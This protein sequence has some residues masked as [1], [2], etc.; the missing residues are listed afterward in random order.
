MNLSIVSFEPSTIFAGE[1]YSETGR[2]MVPVGEG[3]APLPE[4]VVGGFWIA[5]NRNF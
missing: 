3:T 2:F 4:M 1:R 5:F